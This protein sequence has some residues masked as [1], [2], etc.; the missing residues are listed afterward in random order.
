MNLVVTGATSFLGAALIKELLKEGHQVYAVVRPGSL[1]RK[2]LDSVMSDRLRIVELELGQLERIGEYIPVSCQ[3]FFHFGWDGSGSENRKKKEVQQ[4]NVSDGVKALEGARRLGCRRFLF[5][6]SQ[7]EYGI[8]RTVM[9]EDRVCCPVSEY[10]KAKTEFYQKA[11]ELVKRWR[12]DAE[13]P[14]NGEQ[15][16][17]AP[18]YIH[19]RI[20]SV[21]GLGDHPWSLVNAC[22]DTFLTGG[23]MK[24][25]ACTQQWNF[26]Y[27][28]DLVKG[29]TA[30]AFSEGTVG[31]RG[32]G[33]ETGIYNVAGDKSATMP[34]RNYVEQM[35]RLCGNKGHFLYGEM[36][37]NAEGQANLIPDIEKIKRKTGWE[38][39]IGFEEGIKRMLEAEKTKQRTRCMVCG[40]PFE[41]TPLMTLEGMP[42]SAQDIPGEQEVES[43]KGITLHLHQC[44]RCGLVQFDCKPVAYYRDV[45][46]SG[47]YSTTMVNLRSRQYR[48]LIENYRLE[49]KKFLEVGCGRGEFLKVLTD[50]PVQAFG[51]EHRKALVETAV[52]DGLNVVYGF[53]ETPDTVLGNQ[54]PYDVFLSFNFLEHQPEPGVMLDCIRKN[55]SE[56][57][58]G[59]VTVPS[60]EYIL[61]H[62]GYYELIRDHIACYTFD[63]LRYLMEQHGFE[64]LEE[65]MVNRDTL[66]VIV[67]K[68]AGW[69][70]EGKNGENGKT[71]KKVKPV[72]ISGLASSLADIRHQME[73]LCERVEAQGQTL[74]VWG[75]SH[76]GFTLAATTC[77]GEKAAYIMDSAPFKQGKFAPASHLP[78]ISPDDFEK[79]PA[80]VILI[81]AP[82]Y[83]EEIAAVIRKRFGNGIQILTLRSE[84]IEALQTAAADGERI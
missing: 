55:L 42:A 51:V 29:L 66:S 13:K 44:S 26:L 11:T 63:T 39:R 73:Q 84:R 54:G 58:M 49:G 37:P 67:K 3:V 46:R 38:P 10:G 5:S 52:A 71:L 32:D 75:A 30:L 15:E 76:Q 80:D 6:G 14:G 47:G 28:D 34:L 16:E 24:L 74:A 59:L 8:C 17:P 82:G 45:I 83:T 78:I 81:V 4:Q 70:G 23:T 50:F 65:E 9:T 72:D 69:D 35:Y 22:L 33:S 41:G 20:F 2:A 36:P 79:Q 25:G 64:V 21:Y 7:A 68:K 53:T 31:Y 43:D 27:I 12:R 77:L 60:F 19:A 61:Q 18:E 62:D 57:G 56:D 40:Q 1:N 48:H